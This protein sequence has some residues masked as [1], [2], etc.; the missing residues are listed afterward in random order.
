[1]IIQID[2][3]KITDPNEFGEILREYCFIDKPCMTMTGFHKPY[4]CYSTFE[5]KKG[6]IKLSQDSSIWKK[7][8][9][10]SGYFNGDERGGFFVFTK[11]NIHIG[12]YWD[13][14]GCLV[15]QEGNKIAVNNDC[16]C[17]YT[18]EWIYEKKKT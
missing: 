6:F 14:D 13:G 8:A 2:T 17:D 4:G 5:L 18:W 3:Q 16:K 11:G 12:W 7:L 1:M 9:E 10:L 15:I